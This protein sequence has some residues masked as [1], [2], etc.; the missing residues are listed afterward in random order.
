MSLSPESAQARRVLVPLLLSVGVLFAPVLAAVIN[1]AA[2]YTPAAERLSAADLDRSGLD[3]AGRGEAAVIAE[4]PFLQL[5]LPAPTAAPA[6]APKPTA[7]TTHS[8][9]PTTKAEAKAAPVTAAPKPTTPPTTARTQFFNG[10]G[11]R[12]SFYSAAAPGNCAHR[13]LPKG[14]LVKIT[15]TRN[16]T[17]V[18]C[19]VTDRGPYVDGRIIDLSKADF[20][21]LSG[22]HVGVIDVLIEW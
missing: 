6:P 10:Q 12:A 18:T 11:G 13:T 8:H 21:R 2:A 14:T 5:A 20:E 1:R 16:G 15:N 17:S 7:T 3:R 4:A 19:T 22:S 9:P